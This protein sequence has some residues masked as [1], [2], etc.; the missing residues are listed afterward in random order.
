MAADSR[1]PSSLTVRLDAPTRDALGEYMAA[2]GM[3]LSQAVRVLLALALRD[4]NESP[5]KAFRAAAFREGVT[6]GAAKLSEVVQDSIKRALGDME[7]L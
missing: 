6:A 2:N 7:A 4:E 1:V 3:N 5:D